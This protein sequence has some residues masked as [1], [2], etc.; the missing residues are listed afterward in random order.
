MRLSLASLLAILCVS[1]S[2][3]PPPSPTPPPPPTPP[4]SPEATAVFARA[5][6]PGPGAALVVNLD[7]FEAL[8]LAGKGPTMQQLASVSTAIMS[9]LSTAE[10]SEGQFFARGAVVSALL[11]DWAKWP[12][13]RRIAFLVPSDRV[14]ADG[15]GV[16]PQVAVG[17]LAV[18]EGS[19][20]N[21]QLL[22]AV[23]ALVRAAAVEVTR[24]GADPRVVLQGQDV[25]VVGKELGFPVCV[26]PRRG[27][28]LF[29]TPTALGALEALP[30]VTAPA[31]APGEAPLLLGLRVDLGAKGRARLA[32]TGRDAVRLALHVEGTTAKDI[33]MAE[34]LVKKALTDYDAHQA[35]VRQRIATGLS[36]VQRSIAQDPAA[37]ATLKQAATG[38]TADRVVDEKGYWAQ[39]RQSV[40][41]SST[42]DSLSLSLTVPAGAV[43][44]MSEQMAS[45]GTPV[46]LVG[47]MAAIAIPN[48]IKFQAR[49]KQSEA[50]MN[51]KAAYVAQRAY[52][53]EKDRLGRTFEEIGFAPEPGRRY[54]Y[55]MGKQCLPCDRK[56]C[57]VAPE[58]S[59]CQGLTT[60]GKSANDNFSICAYGNVDSDAAWDVWV[61]D[62]S[63]EP[64]NL[65]NDME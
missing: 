46:A 8:G 55:C 57:K 18:D 10:G 20:D 33:A 62:K 39:A 21:A 52:V 15:A 7:A 49:A 26:R 45:G 44:D 38:L 36:E 65:S 47:I 64:E 5:E 61:I 16:L 11:R 34:S 3:T 63:G 60:L 40:Q 14:L 29:G 28:I 31:A 58:P 1:C 56:D 24:E 43:K 42:Q 27:L 54:T 30:P 12:G 48:F 19:P 32:F 4:L 37:P 53:M 35:E 2:T 22:S 41:V 13:L 23:V 9:Q 50:K 17:A 6:A 25:C 59:P 51:L